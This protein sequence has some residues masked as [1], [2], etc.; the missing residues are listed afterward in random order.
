MDVR[1]EGDLH[2]TQIVEGATGG[3]TWQAGV[4]LGGVTSHWGRDEA[5]A[6][7]EGVY[8]HGLVAAPLSVQLGNHV[9]PLKV[10]GLGA[11]VYA[12]GDDVAETSH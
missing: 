7:A 9:V 10:V 5:G 6:D 11:G 3:L 1:A 4:V 2:S 8:V 12:H